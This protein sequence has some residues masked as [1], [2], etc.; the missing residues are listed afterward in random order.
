MNFLNGD[1]VGG[2]GCEIQQG[3]MIYMLKISKREYCLDCYL[4]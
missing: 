3:D 1:T 4:F 2:N